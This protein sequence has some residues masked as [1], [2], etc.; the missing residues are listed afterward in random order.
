[1]DIAFTFFLI[2][3]GAAALASL[4]LFSRQPI[5]ISYL[6]IGAMIGPYGFKLVDNLEVISSAGH[7]G[8]IF[9]LFLLGLEMKIKD[10]IAVAKE[11]S[12]VVVL[13]SLAFFAGA[14]VIAHLFGVSNMGSIIIGLCAMF[15]ST[16]IAIKLLPT[17]VLHHKHAGELMVGLLLLQ[18]I[19]AI[20]VLIFLQQQGDSSKS[21][22]LIKSLLGFAGLIVISLALVKYVLLKLIQRFDNFHEYIFLLAIA[23]C[24][25]IAELGKYLG[26]SLEIGAFIAGVALAS[27][28]ISLYIAEQLKPLRNFFLVIFFFAVGASFNFK[29]LPQIIFPALALAAFIL[30][31]KPLIY[32]ILLKKFSN[33]ESELAKDIGFRLGQGS[34]FALLIASLALH[35][36]VINNIESHII[37]AAVLIS[38][39]VSSYIV[40]TRFPNPIA[41]DPK[42][43][44][45]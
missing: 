29:M 41:P 7:I 27:S 20:C 45:D 23:W 31:L 12:I 16:I 11:A 13:S 4:A 25:G 40:V 1:M 28:P 22:A 5:I 42:L 32:Q 34:E 36:G 17:T 19:L 33:E 26:A 2:F 14:Y 8:I 24:M 10:L 9:L 6:L 35:M 30:V 18:D 43:R 3:A 39:I 44:R 37:Q 38:F 15:S 21:Y